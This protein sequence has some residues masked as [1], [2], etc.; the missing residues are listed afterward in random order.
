MAKTAIA[1]P[2]II[3]GLDSS[4]LVKGLNGTIG[5]VGSL[6]KKIGEALGAAIMSPLNALKIGTQLSAPLNQALELMGKA[7]RVLGAPV[8]ALMAREQDQA[9]NAGEPIMLATSTTMTG[10]LARFAHEIEEL[11]AD[12]VVGLDKAFNFRAI[13]EGFRGIVS[14][15][16]SLLVAAFGPLIAVA[17][18]KQALDAA[19]AAGQQIAVEGFKLIAEGLIDVYAAI[20]DMSNYVIEILN[21]FKSFKPLDQKQEDAIAD[22]IKNNGNGKGFMAPIGP[23]GM[24]NNAL[25]NKA[26]R[27][28]AIKAL[29]INQ[30][31]F[32]EPVNARKLK[33]DAQDIADRFKPADPAP[34]RMAENAL[35]TFVS[36]LGDARSPLQ[37][38]ANQMRQFEAN[39]A[40]MRNAIMKMPFGQEQLDAVARYN[41]MIE[42]GDILLGQ[43]LQGILGPTVQAMGASRITSAAEVGSG[44][45]VEAIV[46][47]SAQGQG[48][49]IQQQIKAA[50]DQQLVQQQMQTRTQKAILEAARAGG[51]IGLG[52]I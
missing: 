50:I 8:R 13:L 37:D 6:G 10:V 51:L 39:A 45:L 4:Q 19:F 34:I 27:E 29:K 2:T 7:N 49:D 5:V 44:A 16:R 47:A 14:G 12:L 33:Q 31:P 30:E 22:W 25:L 46:R 23:W 20:I 11:A 48:G 28:D 1:N 15:I 17:N 35:K 40:A 41:Q 3:L 18:D 42:Q 32:F 21:F 26:N 9:N 24:I 38:M 52:K 36:T 43:R